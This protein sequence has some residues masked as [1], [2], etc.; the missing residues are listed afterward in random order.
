MEGNGYDFCKLIKRWT[1]FFS[2]CKEDIYHFVFKNLNFKLINESFRLKDFLITWGLALSWS[3]SFCR[4][5]P[6][7]LVFDRLL[8][9]IAWSICTRRTV[10][11]AYLGESILLTTCKKLFTQLR[12]QKVITLAAIAYS[13][14]L[15]LYRSIFTHFSGI[16]LYCI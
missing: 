2:N 5:L 6:F 9:L 12:K 4:E 11:H 10:P 16:Q 8:L 1:S 15:Y 3:N 14:K 13:E 7:V